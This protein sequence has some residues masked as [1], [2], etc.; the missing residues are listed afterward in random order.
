MT[1]ALAAIDSHNQAMTPAQYGQYVAEAE[2]KARVL[3]DIVE[4]QKLYTVIGSKKHLHVEAWEVLG[5]GYGLSARTS[6]GSTEP[7][8]AP[9]GELLGVRARVEIVDT[10]GIARGGAESFCTYDEAETRRDGTVYKRWEGHPLAQ[11]AGMAQTRATARAYRQMIAWVVQLAGYS[12]TPFEELDADRTIV[13]GQTKPSENEYGT[14]ETHK[15]PY[16]KT[17]KMRSPAHRNPDGTWCNKPTEKPAPPQP[18]GTDPTQQD[19]P[20]VPSGVGAATT[21][22]NRIGAASDDFWPKVRQAFPALTSFQV[23]GILQVKQ[24]TDW[25]G[26]VDEA[27]AAVR[28]KQTAGG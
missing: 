21:P 7:L 20:P 19:T 25:K 16:F 27:L 10:N 26:S 12:P 15:V 11:L 28:A 4:R 9:T 24:F 14:C 3:T 22:P 2:G 8:Y 17:G 13:E 23:L 6:P 5:A 1:Q 18:V